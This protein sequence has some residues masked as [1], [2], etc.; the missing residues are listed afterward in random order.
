MGTRTRVD[1]WSN[2]SR[3]LTPGA[4]P[5][6]PPGAESCGGAVGPP[7]FSLELAA[8][9]NT[10]FSLFWQNMHS[11][12]GTFSPE[13][14]PT[15]CGQ[16]WS[17][18]ELFMLSPVT[19]EQLWGELRFPRRL[20]LSSHGFLPSEA[21]LSRGRLAS[22]ARAVAPCARHPHPYHPFFPTSP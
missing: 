19:G 11:A 7:P 15:L 3:N 9:Q 22:H 14:I 8:P 6:R 5:E 17:A 16:L 4:A 2:A 18:A 1:L 12:I 10:N 21:P 20:I 13:F